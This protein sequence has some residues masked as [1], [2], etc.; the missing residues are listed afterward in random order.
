M[1]ETDLLFWHPDRDPERAQLK[2]ELAQRG[3]EGW[4][5]VQAPWLSATPFRVSVVPPP[6]DARQMF[7]LE[8]E[9]AAV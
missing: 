1:T 5:V 9:T 7:V 2:A 4:R 3:A 6:P 8:R